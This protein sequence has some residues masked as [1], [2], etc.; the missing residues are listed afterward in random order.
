MGDQ[1]NTI[2]IIT[3]VGATKGSTSGYY[4][5]QSSSA[6]Q[7]IYRCEPSKGDHTVGVACAAA[8]DGNKTKRAISR[9]CLTLSSL[10]IV[11]RF[12]SAVSSS[13]FHGGKEG[14]AYDHF[15]IFRGLCI[16]AL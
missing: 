6:S 11:T 12:P 13:E 1:T 2:T 8:R 7:T 15:T 5:R 10:P 4:L 3:I 14:N 9:F 16:A